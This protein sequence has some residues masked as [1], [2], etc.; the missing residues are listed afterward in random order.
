MLRVQLLGP[1]EVFDDGR[2]LELGGPQQ[3]AV[4]AHL[5][6]ELGRVVSV[7][8][9]VDRLWGDAPPR[10]P[11][12]TLQSYVSRL[13]RALEPGRGHGQAPTVL[14][15]EA[16]GYVL[17]LAPEQIDLHRF[18]TLVGEV[19]AAEA[20][21][22]IGLLDEALALWR[23]PALAGIGP[24]EAVAQLTVRITE[25]HHAAIEQRFEALL[26]VG[27]AAEAVPALQE[28]VD[29][30]P[31]RERRWALL[32]L[33]LYRSRRQAEALRA[34]A[35]ARH[36]LLDE[37]GLD[38][39]PELRDLEARIL[40]QDPTLDLGAAR[41]S[42]APPAAPERTVPI[43]PA[44]PLLVRREAEWTAL[45]TALQR[46]D[47][48]PA[49][50]AL[51]DGEPGIGKSTI[52]GALVDHAR[53]AGWHGA[54]GRCVEPGLAPSLWPWIEIVRQLLTGRGAAVPAGRGR[55]WHQLA[56]GDRDAGAVLSPVELAGAF[57]D[58]LDDIDEYPVLVAL[59]D[60][61][62]A[63]GPTID[64][65]RLVVERLARRRVFVV[66]AFRQPELVP[67]SLLATE[68]ARLH[69]ATSN[70]VRL[71]IAP[72][73]GGQIADLIELTTGTAP[74]PDVVDRI[75]RSAGGN[76][77]F[78][79]E[80]ARLAGER[81][82]DGD[83]EVPTAIRDVVRGRLAPL[84]ER[85]T[86]ELEVAAVLGER[87]ELRTAM[88]ASERDADSC[89][90][91]LDAAIVTRIL[92]PDGEGF[93]FAH[94]LVR[95]SVLADVPPLRLARL[96]H[97]AAEAILAV[98]G[99][100]ADEAEPIAF[101]RIASL[102]LADPLIVAKSV[103]RAADVARWTGALDAA[104]RL[105][106]RTLEILAGRTRTDAVDALEAEALE[107][108]VSAAIRRGTL[109]DIEAATRRVVD[110]AE[111]ANSDAARALALFV[112]WNLI[113][114]H[115]ARPEA[116]GIVAEATA[117]AKSTGS[118]YATMMSRYVL[119]SHALAVG[120]LDA[121][122]EHLVASIVALGAPEPDDQPV[123]VPLAPVP[124]TASLVEALRGD[125][126]EARGSTP[127]GGCGRG[128]TSA[129]TWTRTWATS[130]PTTGRSS[131]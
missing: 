131:R 58:L 23:G 87:F 42:S 89:L 45:A 49:Q 43:E 27:R 88:A 22:A 117:L 120:E 54:V 9:L 72:L 77:L 90:D 31:L 85:A 30:E 32:A 33:A 96:H 130:S 75:R 29:A 80:L 97:R 119:G 98:R 13:R 84:P 47:V 81:G 128:P 7:D 64:V 36:A 37:L 100:G 18:R 112:R 111:A 101:H 26:A 115:P 1:V 129:S 55:P 28:A 39:G 35:A 10:S 67:D 126:A 99:D 41:V 15:S 16:P 56:A 57:V 3:R 21:T 106:E 125:A 79:C 109:A 24:D 61:H 11:L 4:I 38:P 74:G 17:R 2:P 63:D 76:P 116:A 118:P 82:L 105:A 123:H 113:D 91:A 19:R 60:L 78:V 62:W 66:A 51:V 5:A 110:F 52:V 104:D 93:R 107:S 65:L 102:R 71:R 25:E 70:P 12:G 69:V 6:L 40:A 127:I 14:V 46:A 114:L 95:D 8:R 73:D 83:L 34:L 108:I 94:A 92:V 48:G 121:A 20:A 53:A 44:A 122:H 86:A 103:V 68:L 124:Y 50:L 59:D